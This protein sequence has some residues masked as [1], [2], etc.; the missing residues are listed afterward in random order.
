MASLPV[1]TLTIFSTKDLFI[2][3]KG[4]VR[5]REIFYCL[6]H[7]PKDHNGQRWVRP[8]P[9]TRG[10]SGSPTWLPWALEIELSSIA[11]LGT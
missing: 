4:T 6:I 11:F 7:S 10:Y 8:K 1:M 3:L 5:K 2:D 9:R